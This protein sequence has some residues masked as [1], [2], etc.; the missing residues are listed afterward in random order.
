MSVFFF[1]EW[2]LLCKHIPTQSPRKR[3]MIIKNAV[4][5]GR[6]FARVVLFWA[7]AAFPSDV[8]TLVT[9]LICVVEIVPGIIKSAGNVLPI[10]STGDAVEGSVWLVVGGLISKP[11]SVAPLITTLMP[12]V[13]RRLNM[14]FRIFSAAGSETAVTA[15][16]MLPHDANGFPCHKLPPIFS[17]ISWQVSKAATAKSVSPSMQSVLK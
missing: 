2:F 12:P 11:G 17:S 1:A 7:C 8:A 5:H 4:N 9:I 10:G 15:T 6:A 13:V 3:Q 16:T 14:W